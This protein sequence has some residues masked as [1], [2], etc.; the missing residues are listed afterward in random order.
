MSASQSTPVQARPVKTFPDP[1]PGI[2]P[3]GSLCLIA[4]ASGA[5]KTIFFVEWIKRWQDG[6]TICEKPTNCPTG[7]YYLAADRDWST[8]REALD[9]AGVEDIPHYVLAEDPQLDPTKWSGDEALNFLDQCLIRLKPLPGSIVIIDPMIPL[10]IKGD[11]NR[12]RDVAISCHGIRKLALKYQVTIIGMANVA[13]AKVGEEHK[14][15][16]DRIAGSG[17][18]VAY[19]DTQIYV[20]ESDDVKGVRTLGWTPRRGAAEE[21]QFTFDPQTKLFVPYTGLQDDGKTEATDRPSQ[22]LKLIPDDGIDRGDLEELAMEKFKCARSTVGRDLDVLR[23][24]RLIVWD[25]WGRISR[26]KPS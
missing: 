7:F 20:Q 5:G 14:R 10:F 2:I 6:R 22:L 15:P 8:Y 3:F 16:Q 18:L 1:I 24:N 19:T 11:S 26:R 13:K 25:S 21:W 23:R 12:A 9:C 17:A 4:G